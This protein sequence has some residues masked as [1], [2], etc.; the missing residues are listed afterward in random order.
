MS[1]Q[2]QGNKRRNKLKAK[3]GREGKVDEVSY[4]PWLHID[5]FWLNDVAG[6]LIIPTL[7]IS[8]IPFVRSRGP[9]AGS[10][11]I[12]LSESLKATVLL[13]IRD[14]YSLPIFSHPLW[15]FFLRNSSNVPQKLRLC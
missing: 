8:Y 3:N 5:G 14:T 6:M 12:E 4:R 7:I 9:R 10:N 15:H 11:A 2:S 13:Y 1:N